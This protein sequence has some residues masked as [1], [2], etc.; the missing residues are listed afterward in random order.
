[1]LAVGLVML[2]AVLAATALLWGMGVGPE[3]ST[4]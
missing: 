3:L 4:I 1:V 2:V